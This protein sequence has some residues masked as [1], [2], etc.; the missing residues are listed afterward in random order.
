MADEPKAPL[1]SV[2]VG[3]MSANPSV[4]AAPLPHAPRLGI[5][6]NG[7]T[8]DDLLFGHLERAIRSKRG[9]PQER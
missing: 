1:L 4:A 9:R 7:R 5:Q 8:P 3:D 2:N 6:I